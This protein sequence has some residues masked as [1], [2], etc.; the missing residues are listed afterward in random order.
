MTMTD[1]TD[2]APAPGLSDSSR[3]VLLV[4]SGIGLIVVMALLGPKIGPIGVGTLI[5]L[6]VAILA[7]RSALHGHRDKR[8]R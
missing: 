2:E 3:S 6:V 8:L 4:A 1:S 7:T 5:A